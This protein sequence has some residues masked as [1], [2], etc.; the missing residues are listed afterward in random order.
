MT[1]IICAWL[2][3]DEGYKGC[4]FKSPSEAIKERGA[5]SNQRDQETYE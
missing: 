1:I 3:Y 5:I 4:L 2:E